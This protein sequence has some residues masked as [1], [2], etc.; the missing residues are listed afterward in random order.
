LKNLVS[1]LLKKIMLRDL[2]TKVL[3]IH[4]PSGKPF[5][6]ADVTTSL[7]KELSDRTVC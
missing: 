7:F 5:P 1:K 4:E 6:T 3:P 2:L